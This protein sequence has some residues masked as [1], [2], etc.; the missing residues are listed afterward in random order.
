[1]A[2]MTRDFTTER[3]VDF[4]PSVGEPRGS[5]TETLLQGGQVDVVRLELS[6]GRRVPK[7]LSSGEIVLQCLAGHAT[8]IVSDRDYELAAGQ[9]L[10]LGARVPYAIDAVEDVMLLI[11]CVHPKEAIQAESDIVEEA[12]NE[13]FPASDAPGWTGTSL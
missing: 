8:I 11:L 4:L 12:S 9:L 6:A 3:V 7:H 5:A 10:H 2:T 1:M 13:S